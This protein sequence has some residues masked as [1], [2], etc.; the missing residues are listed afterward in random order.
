MVIPLFWSLHSAYAFGR[1]FLTTTNV[2]VLYDSVSALKTPNLAWV[3]T[4]YGEH[5]WVEPALEEG[6][7]LTSVV[8]VWQWR[9][10]GLP[11]PILIASRDAVPPDG[12]QVGLLQD[13]IPLYEV[14]GL[15]YAYVETESGIFP[16]LANGSGGN[17]TVECTNTAGGRLIVQENSWNGWRAY[18]DQEPAE[19][20]PGPLLS[21]DARPGKHVYQ[22]VYRPWDVI[23]GILLTMAGVGL[24]LALGMKSEFSRPGSVGVPGGEVERSDPPLRQFNDNPNKL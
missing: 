23:L 11:S 10:R 22:F 19:L 12:V 15:D 8:S 14:P 2:E 18:V 20:R 4:P 7:K 13:T 16:C 24:A 3:S 17:L 21:T 9:G 6:L 1:I 5:F